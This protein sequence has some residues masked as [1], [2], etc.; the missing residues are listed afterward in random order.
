[1]NAIVRQTHT[2][3]IIS[4][5]A[6]VLGW[7]LL[8]V[9]GSVGAIVFGHMAR[10]QIRREPERYDGDGLAVAGLVLGWINVGL[11]IFGIVALVLFFGG[12]A[13]LAALLS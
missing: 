6:G 11:V 7:T 4:L 1:M 3:A 10:G 9:L 5:V 8:P 13:G 2:Y 12:L